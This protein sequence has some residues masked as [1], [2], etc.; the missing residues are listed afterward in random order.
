M[1]Q[2]HHHRQNCSSNS[3]A[4]QKE[5]DAPHQK[6]WRQIQQALVSAGLQGVSFW[7][8]LDGLGTLPEG[9]LDWL[10]QIIAVSTLPGTLGGQ[11]PSQQLQDSS[12]ES[13]QSDQASLAAICQSSCAADA[14]GSSGDAPRTLQNDKGG[15][16]KQDEVTQQSFVLQCTA[17][18][19]LRHIIEE[20]KQG[21]QETITNVQ[22]WRQ[23]ARGHPNPAAGDGHVQDTVQVE[24]TTAMSGDSQMQCDEESGSK[25]TLL[26]SND[27]QQ[28]AGAGSCSS[29]QFDAASGQDRRAA[30]DAVGTCDLTALLTVAV[31]G[32]AALQATLAGLA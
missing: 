4:C 28:A 3:P 20:Q 14:A 25:T 22:Q 31:D 27:L 11:L 17:R 13:H 26:S 6:Q 24:H 18:C 12:N 1:Q 32:R 15:N 8:E 2:Q 7:V 29:S 5:P 9:L 21:L 30:D 19:V 10:G 23:Q 16:D